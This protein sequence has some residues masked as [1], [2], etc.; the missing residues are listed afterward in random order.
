MEDGSGQANVFP[1]L[2]GNAVVQAGNPG[3]M[4]HMILDG[5]R[6]AATAGNPTGL[7]MPSFGWK[8]SDQDIADLASYLR[9]AWGNRAAAVSAADVKKTRERVADAAAGR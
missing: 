5:A 7:A 6:I 4:L 2:K 3:T 9:G 8:L 1:P